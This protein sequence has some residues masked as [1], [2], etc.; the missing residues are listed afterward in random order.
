M[1]KRKLS[2]CAVAMMHSLLLSTAQAVEFPGPP[3]GK[4]VATAELVHY[5]LEN[6]A[7]GMSWN[8]ANG[9]LQPATVVD[10]LANKTI[11]GGN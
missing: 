1:S 8:V 6:A 7:I 11:R 9:R 10:R 5:R 2:L 3:P 4:P